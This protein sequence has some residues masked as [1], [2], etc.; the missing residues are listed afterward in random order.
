MLAIVATPIGN[1]DDIT[2]RAV[3]VL[4][5]SDV[6]L[7]EDTRHTQKL[8]NHLGIERT[9]GTVQSYHEHNAETRTVWALERLTQG[10][11]IALVTDAGTPAISDP[12]YR[13]V[14]AAREAGFAVVPI[15][16]PCAAIAAL[17]A[18]GL[19]TDRFTFVGFPPK[20]SGARRRWLEGLAPIGGSIVIY[21]AGRDV[22]KLL[23]GLLETRG[24]VHIAL[25][26]ELTKQYEEW[27]TG[28]VSSVLSDW[29]GNP[30]KGEVTIV[31]D[32]AAEEIV[33]DESL[34]ELLRS[35]PVS[36]VV[37]LT[38]VSKRRVYQLSIQMKKNH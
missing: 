33:D 5:S 3:Q 36:E 31:V 7:A 15:P 8:L 9:R 1:L 14:R 17:S 34:Q 30:R 26:R 23:S 25:A 29:E 4:R 32:R 35:H 18:S 6:I 10:Q 28:S 21:A 16:G 38:G 27:L 37:E 19:P 11:Q 2:L 12:G 20:K 13:L 22:P 24:D